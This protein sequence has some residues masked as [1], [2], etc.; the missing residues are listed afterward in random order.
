MRFASAGSYA[1]HCTF[2]S[3][4][5]GRVT[6][7]MAATGSPKAGWKLRWLAG[8]SPKGRSYD[9]QVRRRGTKTWREVPHRDH[10]GQRSVRPGLGEVAGAGPVRQG[11]VRAV[12]VVAGAHAARPEGGRPSYR[13]AVV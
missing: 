7:P 8:V 10:D 3:M 13:A 11:V 12:G 5:H 6:V 1:Y 9:V 4:M 2:H